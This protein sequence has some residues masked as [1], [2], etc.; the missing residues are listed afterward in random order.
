MDK[1]ADD[2]INKIGDS[3][4]DFAMLLAFVIWCFTI[5]VLCD[6]TLNSI[7]TKTTS[8]QQTI[9]L[10]EP[11]QEDSL[12][13][14]T[15]AKN[16]FEARYINNNGEEIAIPLANDCRIFHKSGKQNKISYT[17]S[18]KYNIFNKKISETATKVTIY[19]MPIQ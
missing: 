5:V 1:D 14:V 3:F 10:T 4:S 7:V 12:S 8:S 15:I 9:Q 18:S 6:L 2:I 13:Y 11:I 19:K 16:A 17:E